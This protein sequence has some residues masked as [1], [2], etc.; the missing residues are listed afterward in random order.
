M[1]H[2]GDNMDSIIIFLLAYALG[3]LTVDIA[4]TINW[5]INETED[6]ENEDEENEDEKK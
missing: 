1:K 4:F 5:F 3:I 6:E 2:G